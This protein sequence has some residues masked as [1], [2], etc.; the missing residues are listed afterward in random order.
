MKQKLPYIHV[1]FSRLISK[2]YQALIKIQC[3]HLPY[4]DVVW[5]S[6]QC[7]D[8]SSKTAVFQWES[9]SH[10][11]SFLLVQ[12]DKKKHSLIIENTWF[13]HLNDILIFPIF[14]S[15]SIVIASTYLKHSTGKIANNVHGKK[16]ILIMKINAQH[17]E[18]RKV[19]CKN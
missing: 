16:Q 4:G 11:N 1:R 17:L 15:S 14:T 8:Y 3:F 12:M 19:F 2:H 7:A 10:C 9:L 18:I 5:W 13:I 6:R